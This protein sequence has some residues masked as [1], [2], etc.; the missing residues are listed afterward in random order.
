VQ[1]SGNCPGT[2]GAQDAVVNGVSLDVI[3]DQ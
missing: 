3:R 1:V 2:T